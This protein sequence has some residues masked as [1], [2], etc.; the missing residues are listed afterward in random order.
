MR[1]TCD[2]LRA[3][4]W[5]NARTPVRVFSMD[6]EYLGFKPLTSTLYSL[7]FSFARARAHSDLYDILTYPPIYIFTC[8]TRELDMGGIERNG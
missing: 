7:L 6:V 1:P 3:I 5:L 8:V 4:F 2:L